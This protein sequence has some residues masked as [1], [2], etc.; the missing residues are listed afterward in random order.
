MTAPKV[1]VIGLSH[2]S[3][4]SDRRLSYG[5]IAALL[6]AAFCLAAAQFLSGCSTPI[7]RVP[8]PSEDIIKANEAA[9]DADLAFARKNY[10]AALIKYLEAA[11]LNPNSEFIHNKLGIA[12]SQLKYYTEAA[13]AF[14]RSIGLNPKYPYS[15]NNLGTVHFAGGEKKKAEKY[16]RKAIS[17][18]PNT[19]SFHVNLG[20]LYFEMGKMQKGMAEFRKGL[21]IDPAIMGKSDSISLSAAGAQRSPTERAYFLARLFASMG[22]AERAVENLKQALNAGFLNLEAIRKEPDFDPIRED[23]RFVAFMKSATLIVKP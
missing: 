12:Y 10:Y 21:A 3:P 13:N 7:V 15:Y 14:E 18:S 8:V 6:F 5:R 2:S 19:A 20:T 4:C 23:Q 9:R 16:F 1:G 11:R 22:D 17:L